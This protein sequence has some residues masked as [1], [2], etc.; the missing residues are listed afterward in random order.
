MSFGWF[1]FLVNFFL[2]SNFCTN[3]AFP[4]YRALTPTDAQFP[5]AD[6]RLPPKGKKLNRS[7]LVPGIT[8]LAN[9]H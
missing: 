2:C 5:T 1:Y 8:Y 7:E 6:S 9:L 4:L 3:H